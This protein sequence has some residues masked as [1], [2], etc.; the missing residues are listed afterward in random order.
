MLN[1]QTRMWV[2]GI[3]WLAAVLAIVGSSVAVGANLSTSALLFVVCTAPLALVRLIGFGA[4]P[5]TVAEVLYAANTPTDR[6]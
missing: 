6:R 5:P 4:P 1:H 3:G 2:L